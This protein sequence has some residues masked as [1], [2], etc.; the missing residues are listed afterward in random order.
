MPGA[1]CGWGACLPQGW[2]G[3]ILAHLEP[4]GLG[5]IAGVG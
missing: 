1:Q 4:L 5:S 2:G 3:R